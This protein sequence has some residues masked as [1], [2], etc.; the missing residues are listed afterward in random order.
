M[1]RLTIALGIWEG[2]AVG[3]RGKGEEALPDAPAASSVLFSQMF[4]PQV[5]SRTACMRVY[6]P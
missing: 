3:S 6:M 1:T 4:C 5:N 2:F